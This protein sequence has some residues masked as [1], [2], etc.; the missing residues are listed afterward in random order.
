MTVIEQAREV[1]D[2][3]RIEICRLRATNQE[4]LGALKRVQMVVDGYELR[5]RLYDTMAYV[6]T[7]IDK[8]ERET[9]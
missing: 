9:V 4:L 1:M 7:V 5:D 3:A 8:T 2:A 6:D